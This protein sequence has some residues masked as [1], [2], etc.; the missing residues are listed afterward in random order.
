WLLGF[1]DL[2]LVYTGGCTDLSLYMKQQGFICYYCCYRCYSKT[3]NPRVL[4]LSIILFFFVMGITFTCYIATLRAITRVTNDV[5]II[6]PEIA[7]TTERIVTR[8]I[9]A[10]VL[11][12]LIQWTP[13][14]PWVFAD[15]FVSIILSILTHSQII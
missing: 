10:Y 15:L 9:V 13:A 8:K 14:M 6:S 3:N 12:F 11:I 2:D 5:K 1:R 7:T 4:I